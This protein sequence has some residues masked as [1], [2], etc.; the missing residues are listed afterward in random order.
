MSDVL[1]A[2]RVSGQER[3]ISLVNIS[4]P[5]H[6]FKMRCL[7]IASTAPPQQVI[8]ITA[9]N[10][11]STPSPLVCCSP[12]QSFAFFSLGS[13]PHLSVHPVTPVIH[14][15]CFFPSFPPV[16]LFPPSLWQRTTSSK[17][18][19]RHEL[20]TCFGAF[21]LLAWKSAIIHFFKHHPITTQGDI[22]LLTRHNM[23]EPI[24]CSSAY[25]DIS[26]TFMLW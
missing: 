6:I 12:T 13:L 17:C 20:S 23:S 3:G 19:A 15:F 5:G 8:L 22:K 9:E 18:T 14:L 21:F 2:C 7:H 26:F 16:F 10:R 1:I 11:C 24:P 25:L 4:Q